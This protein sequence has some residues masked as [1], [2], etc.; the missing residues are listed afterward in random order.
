M[1]PVPP[2]CYMQVI[3]NGIMLY[4]GSPGQRLFDIDQLDTKDIVG[5]EFH[6]VATQPLQY[7]GTS[8]ATPCGTVI[9]WT[10]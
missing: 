7:N 8:G 10:K 6:T 3:V 5:F 2:A 4:N 1:E 9:I